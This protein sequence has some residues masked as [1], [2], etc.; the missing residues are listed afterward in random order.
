MGTPDFAVTSLDAIVQAGH[1]VAAVVT[2]PDRPTGRGLKLT[3]SPVKNYA[4]ERRLRLV[5]PAQLRAPADVFAGAVWLSPPGLWP[6][7]HAAGP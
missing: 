6:C 4:V 7:A 5:L 1:D 3:T 2:V